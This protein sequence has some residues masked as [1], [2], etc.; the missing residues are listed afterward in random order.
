MSSDTTAQFDPYYK[1]LG[2]PPAE[3]PANHYRLL[4]VVLFENDGDVIAAAADRQ[5]AHVKSFAMGPHAR[6]SQQLLNELARARVCLLNDRRKADYD[7]K[8]RSESAPQ[9]PVATPPTATPSEP[10]ASTL[11]PPPPIPPSASDARPAQS[12]AIPEIRV[13]VRRRW[14]RRHSSPLGLLLWV[15]ALAGCLVGALLILLQFTG[16]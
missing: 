15:V 2:I 6:E 5:M 13:Q 10:P 7:D 12:G 16:G 11:A 4:G 14:R 3:Q 8:L 1:W 9:A